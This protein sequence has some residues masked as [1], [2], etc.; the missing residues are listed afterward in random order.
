MEVRGFISSARSACAVLLTA[1]SCL[2]IGCSPAIR[3]VGVDLRP[4]RAPAELQA[5]A[6]RAQGGDKRAQL[7]LGTMFEE[8]RSVRRDLGRAARLYGNA[9][10]GRAVLV[11]SPPVGKDAYG[12][13]LRVGDDG[14]GLPEAK[15]KLARLQRG[16]TLSNGGTGQ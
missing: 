3:Y 4:G 6:Y 8:G 15:R 16:K 9:A 2:A 12:T 1:L 10:E 5:L 11:Y 7:A 13:V 14:S